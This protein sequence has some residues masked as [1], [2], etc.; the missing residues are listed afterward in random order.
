[1]L[2][3]DFQNVSRHNSRVHIIYI[4]FYTGLMEVQ[5]IGYNFQSLFGAVILHKCI[6]ARYIAAICVIM[7]IIIIM[8]HVF[9]KGCGR[10]PDSYLS[11][12]TRLGSV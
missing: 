12:W 6:Q 5:I 2:L 1:M 10:T 11:N 4:T 7:S 9:S 3:L 8:V